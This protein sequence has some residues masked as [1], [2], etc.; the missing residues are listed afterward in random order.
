METIY[1]KTICV[2]FVSNIINHCWFVRN[3]VFFSKAECFT[4]LLTLEKWNL[5]IGFLVC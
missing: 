3:L 2:Y 4:R 5:N 1:Y